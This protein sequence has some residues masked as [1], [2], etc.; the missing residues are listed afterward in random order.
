MLDAM[1]KFPIKPS[2]VA[3]SGSKGRSLRWGIWFVHDSDLEPVLFSVN[4][5]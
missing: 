2:Y 5:E 3:L 1:A 4:K